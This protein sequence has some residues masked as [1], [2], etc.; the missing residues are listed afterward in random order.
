MKKSEDGRREEAESAYPLKKSEDAEASAHEPQALRVLML[1]E[2]PAPREPP[3][4]WARE[5]EQEPEPLEL[6]LRD[7]VL[8]FLRTRS[9][10]L[11]PP[12]REQ[13]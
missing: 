1:A 4:R 8:R 6:E 2:R 3:L 10:A 9:R 7:A 12:G 5:P 13:E 11:A